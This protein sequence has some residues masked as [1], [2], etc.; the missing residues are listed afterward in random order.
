ME[1]NGANRR[2][3]NV[4]TAAPEKP[5]RRSARKADVSADSNKRDTILDTAAILF[6]VREFDGTSMRDIAKLA[7]VSQSLIH[8]HYATKEQLFEAVF[9]RHMREM[10]EHRIRLIKSFLS[11]V[12]SGQEREIEELITI[13]IKPWVDLTNDPREPAR[14]FAKFVIRS[15]YHDDDWSRTVALRYFD[16]VQ[17]LGVLAFRT[18]IPEFDDKAAFRAYFLT[19]SMFYMGLSAPRRLA[20]LSGGG[21]DLAESEALLHHG[22]VFAAAG[23]RALR[24]QI[25]AQ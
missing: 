8:Y 4:T 2:V 21:T 22:V 10:N 13:I 1:R 15:A 19:L 18:L 9:E 20:A 7:N 24:A 17:K 11:S 23:I 3:L 14:E 12:R 6:S 25:R 5:L 16:E